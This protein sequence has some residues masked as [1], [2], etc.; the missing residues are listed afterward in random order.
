[1]AIEDAYV[2]AACPD[3]YFEFSTVAFEKYEGIRRTRTATVVQKSHE[4]RKKA[5]S[6]PLAEESQIAASVKSEWQQVRVKERLD[7]LY[8]YDATAA[9]I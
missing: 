6:S 4:N 3:K 5:F 1:M 7:W 2:V 8:T 9:E